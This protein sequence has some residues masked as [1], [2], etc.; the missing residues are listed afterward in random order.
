MG[1]NR[2]R[3]LAAAALMVGAGLSFGAPSALAVE[4]PDN[5]PIVEPAQEGT[6]PT[7]LPTD[8]SASIT[9]PQDTKPSETPPR[10]PG[11][12]SDPS[13]P[14]PTGAPPPTT[15]A[16]APPPP[17]PAP[18][19]APPPAPAPAPVPAPAPPPA[20]AP[21]PVPA[22]APQIGPPF[23]LPP[24]E[25]EP[26][27]RPS[28]TKTPKSPKTATATPSPSATAVPSGSAS[29]S[30][31]PVVLEPTNSSSAPNIPLLAVLSVII[32]GCV[33]GLVRLFSPSRSRAH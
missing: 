15:P 2:T 12:S 18:A 26:S 31:E 6:V 25:D 14:P 11:P 20:P 4:D 7:S 1:Q 24:V 13:A 23:L 8:P 19:P 28:P 16:P 29:T 22:P 27:E 30:V 9:T 21:I 32:I 17:A 5:P 3:A 33:A 10:K